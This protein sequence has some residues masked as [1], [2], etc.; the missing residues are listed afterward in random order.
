MSNSSLVNYTRLSPNCTKPRNNSIKKITIHH[1]AA[2]LTVEACGNVFA[3]KSRQASSNY[4]IGSDGRVGLYVEEKNRSWCSSSPS[5]DHQAVTIEVAND[6]GASTDWHVSDKA[7]AKLIDLCVDI[8]KRNGIKKLNYTGTTSGNL[9]RHNMFVNT[10]CPGPYLQGKLPYIASEVNK[11]LGN[12]TTTSTSTSS[13]SSKKVS[14]ST[15]QS[16]YNSK[17]GSKLGKIAVDN[18]AG[19][20]TKKHLIKALQYEMNKQYGSG[21]DIDG[22]FG[23]KTKAAFL[24]LT[25]GC[26]GNITWLCQARFYCKGYNPNGLDSSYGPGMKTCVTNYQKQQGLKVD[27]ILGRNTAYKLFN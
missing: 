12:K 14:V 3:P 5:N 19:P 21:L 27:G 11:K 2:N 22:S 24:D 7:L 15:V 18:S 16:K 6:G 25:K 1:M 8:C 4:G 26:Y 23:P 17:F 20:D 9:T 10:T 13:N